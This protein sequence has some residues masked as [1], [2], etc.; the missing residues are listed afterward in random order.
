MPGLTFVYASCKYCKYQLR[1]LLALTWKHCNQIIG[2]LALTTTVKCSKSSY[3]NNVTHSR[4]Y[5][6]KKYYLNAWFQLFKV[7]LNNAI[8]G[9]FNVLDVRFSFNDVI[10]LDHKERA[11]QT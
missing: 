11:L 2:S 9:V 1:G 7:Y 6:L 10:Y 3:V 5:I 8:Y 4:L